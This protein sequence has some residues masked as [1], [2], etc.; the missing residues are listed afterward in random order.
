MFERFTK[1]ARAALVAAAGE[2]RGLSH[3]FLG[4]EHVLLGLLND[5]DSVAGKVLRARGLTLAAARA[6]VARVIGLG[7]GLGSTDADA[8]AAIGV[9]LDAIRAATDEAFGEG[10]LDW[11]MVRS[12]RVVGRMPFT[13]RAKKVLELS[14]R[15][16]IS[17]GHGYI[18]TEHQLLGLIREGRGVAAKILAEHV[19]PL[20]ELRDDVLAELRARSVS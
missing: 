7:A 20:D 2:A 9:D 14:L 6:E 8:L 16:A 5:A 17:L 11:A 15:E 10:A 19:G 12:G 4:T 18:G 13:P 1:R 3:N